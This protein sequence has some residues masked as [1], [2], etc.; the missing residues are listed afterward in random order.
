MSRIRRGLFALLLA[1]LL[2]S[3]TLALARMDAFTLSWWT[4]DGGGGN[5]SGGSYT[6]NGTI[7][8]PDAGGMSGGTFD[9]AGGFWGGVSAPASGSQQVFLPVILNSG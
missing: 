3:A 4:V 6:L 7:G 1:C 5:S 2:L 9:L 8:Q